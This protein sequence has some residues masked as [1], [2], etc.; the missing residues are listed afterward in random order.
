VRIN[1]GRWQQSS[2]RFNDDPEAQRIARNA[3]ML[4]KLI[5]HRLAKDARKKLIADPSCFGASPY[6]L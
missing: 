6:R 1:I 5:D 4:A 3:E 2:G